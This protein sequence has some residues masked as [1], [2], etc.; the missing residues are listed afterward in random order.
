MDHEQLR[1]FVA[2][3][4]EALALVR[5]GLSRQ[6]R[7]PTAD[8]QT[9]MTGHMTSLGKM[10][11]LAQALN[12]EGL[13]AEMDHRADDAMH[14]YVDIIKFGNDAT[15]GGPLIDA[16]VRVACETYGITALQTLNTNLNANQCRELV[17]SLEAIEKTRETTEQVFV[18]EKNWIRGLPFHQR[19][20]GF[21]AMIFGDPTLKKVKSSATLKF[22]AKDKQR[23]ELMIQVAVRAFELEK[24][25]PPK[26]ISD[27]AP[28]YLKTIPTDPLTGTN[29]VWKSQ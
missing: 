14:S 3:N 21:F 22:H 28:D 6:S 17:R 19:F 10:K 9:N 24:G 7:V 18:N 20:T 12:A 16:L 29:M 26:T 13:L 2:K 25:T 15:R 1:A 23:L 4:S 8:A 11:M 5:V 27:L